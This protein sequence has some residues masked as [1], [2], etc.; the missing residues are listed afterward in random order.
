MSD[1]VKRKNQMRMVFDAVEENVGIARIA[2]ASFAAQLDFTL[3]QLDEIKIAVSEAVSN[4]VI[5]AYPAN[6]G[7][8]EF[9][10]ELYED[11]AVYEVRDNGVGIVDIELARRAEFS[12]REEHMGLGFALMESFMDM[13][14]VESTVDRG[15]TVRMVK[16]CAGSAVQ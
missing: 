16:S 9:T 15:T 2:A 7:E 4:V 12:T 8:I 5:H 10:M 3:A 14:T 13:L 6:V 1:T 11:R